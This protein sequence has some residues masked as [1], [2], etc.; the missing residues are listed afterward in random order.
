F[1][2]SFSPSPRLSLS[3]SLP[4]LSECGQL[5]RTPFHP[6]IT[7]KEGFLHKRK[8]EAVNLVTRF[9][10]KKRYFWLSSQTL[11]YSK[12]PDWQVRS[13]IPVHRICAV[14]RVDENAFQHPTM[15]QII[16]QDSEAQGH[17]MY[18]QCKVRGTG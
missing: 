17:I 3:L 9:T 2:V 12:S 16:S 10:F 4:S 18:M 6:S 1:F 5:S 11:S 13:S 7:I 8:A 15:M 14:E